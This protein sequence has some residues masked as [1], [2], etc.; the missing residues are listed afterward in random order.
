[1]A[2]LA[3][4]VVAAA[5][6][7]MR[8]GSWTRPRSRPMTIGLA[9]LSL[10]SGIQALPNQIPT[11]LE[12]VGEAT[13]IVGLCGLC[14]HVAL[15]WSARRTAVGTLLAT[16]LLIAM[17]VA[18]YAGLN[19]TGMLIY[20]ALISSAIFATGFIT[21]ASTFAVLPTPGFGRITLA[22]MGLSGFLV[23]LIGVYGFFSSPVGYPASDPIAFK[24]TAIAIC[25]YGLAPIASRVLNRRA[26][27]TGAARV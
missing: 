14:V 9:S 23:S 11:M 24:G 16:A 8:H 26:A 18:A 15:A 19:R 1:M 7:L 5:G 13:G 17:S 22:L 27:S 3:A 25:L 12:W 10:Y 4:C 20:G 21:M 6:A 2:A